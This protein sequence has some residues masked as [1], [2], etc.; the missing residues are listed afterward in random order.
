MSNLNKMEKAIVSL[1]LEEVSQKEIAHILGFTENNIR[2]K[3]YR[4]KNRLK[5]IL[6]PESHGY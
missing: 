6:K 5:S 2:V 1:M 4:I 3:I